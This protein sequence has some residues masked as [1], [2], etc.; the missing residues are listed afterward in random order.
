MTLSWPVGSHPI[1]D[2]VTVALLAFGLALPTVGGGDALTRLAHEFPAPRL[3]VLRRTARIVLSLVAAG[4]VLFTIAFLVLVPADSRGGWTDIPLAG[5]IRHLSAPGWVQAVLQAALAVTTVLFLV[6]AIQAC[7]VDAG[8]LLRR[9]AAAGVLPEVLAMPHPR[10]G[11]LTKSLDVVTAASVL[12]VLTSAGRVAWLA[13]AYATAIA[14]TVA[15]RALAL[16][17]LRRTGVD[18]L[19]APGPAVA[20]SRRPR[21][22]RP[23]DRRRGRWRP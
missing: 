2:G 8:Q 4:T 23:D 10:L 15:L 3:G 11:T 13:G 7:M 12:L 14:A 20:R 18:G 22:D 1:W 16:A 19:P 9:L 17:H 5:L 6:P 21:R